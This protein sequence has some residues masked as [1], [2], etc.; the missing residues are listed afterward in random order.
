LAFTARVYRRRGLADL[1]GVLV[2]AYDMSAEC[3]RH[4]CDLYGAFDV[5]VKMNSHGSVTGRGD[6]GRVD[7][8]VTLKCGDLMGRLKKK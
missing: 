6:G 3:V 4:A 7:G 5:A 2:D 1:T 8:C